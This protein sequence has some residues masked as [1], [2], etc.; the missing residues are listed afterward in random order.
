MPRISEFYGII[1]SMYFREHNPPHFHAEYNE[2]EATICI[3]DF[4][5]IAGNLPPKALS[6]TIEWASLHKKE[7]LE[8]WQLAQN[9]QPL[10]KIKP[11]K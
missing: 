1:I 9:H 6:I 11:L 2:Y 7:L 4:R 3:N 10:K 5:L 8:N